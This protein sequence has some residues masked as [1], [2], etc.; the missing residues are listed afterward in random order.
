M[1]NEGLVN[2]VQQYLKKGAQIYV[3]GQLNTRKWKDEQSGQDKY[4]T[5]VVIQGYNSSLTMLGGGNQNSMPSQDTK[6]NIEDA[7][8]ATPNDL[9]DDIPF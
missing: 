8:Q 4:S 1:F 6:Q 2:V 5:E 9:D 7:S 3:E